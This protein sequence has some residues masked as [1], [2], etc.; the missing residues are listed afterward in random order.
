MMRQLELRWALALTVSF[1]V[2]SCAQGEAPATET[3]GSTTASAS[4]PVC[5]LPAE[6]TVVRS[7]DGAI[8]ET[9]DLALADVLT[10]RLPNDPAFVEYRQAIE[11]DGANLPRP[12]ADS[13]VTDSEE[14]AAIWRD[15]FF[16]RDLVY[17]SGLGSIDPISC[18][19][20][21]LFT[22][23]AMRVSQVERPTEFAAS[24]LRREDLG[25]TRLKVVFSA[26]SEMFIPR[27][28]YG[29]DL[30]DEYL[31][32]GWTLWYMMHNHTT[33][34]NGDLLALGVPIPSTS[35]VRLIRG[36][37]EKLGLDSIRV[38]NGFYTFSAA[39]N[40]LEEFRAR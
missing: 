5:T 33:Q 25:G 14:L 3:L 36:L 38:T 32:D 31:S 19:D 17:D 27:G 28:W 11:R 24:V 16:N 7:E 4:S 9:W 13:P 1:G 22:R 6:R 29:F 8:L 26:G 12:V 20:A 34:S 39:V 18:L 21:L 15:E 35:D 37:E 40:D 10:D 23:Q 2:I 30:V